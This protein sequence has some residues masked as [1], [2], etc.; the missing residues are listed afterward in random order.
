MAKKFYLAAYRLGRVA[1]RTD[2]WLIAVTAVAALFGGCANSGTGSE[3]ASPEPGRPG[4]IADE[5]TGAIVGVVTDDAFT[6]LEGAAAVLDGQATT[7]TDHGGKFVFGHVA[8]GAHRVAVSLD[9]YQG[10][11]RDVQV[12]A[13]RT[14][15]LSIALLSLAAAQAYHETLIQAGFIACGLSAGAAGQVRQIAVCSVFGS[16]GLGSLDKTFTPWNKYGL[17]MDVTGFWAETTWR[18]TQALSN[19]MAVQW[20][21][22]EKAGDAISGIVT[23]WS[24]GPD[25]IR[26]RVP[27]ELLLNAVV[28]GKKVCADYD[29]PLEA[30]H[31]AWARNNTA[32]DV[33]VVAQQR[34]DDYMTVFH[35][36]ELPV[37]FTALPDK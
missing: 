7:A 35:Y 2:S 29:C 19:R 9:G 16:V 5:D 31:F 8:P 30:W 13:A 37:D 21:A 24:D 12:E 34:Y 23:P 14:A 11:E 32:A 17:G 33:V 26:I 10:Q 27:V 15:E 36:G 20:Y 1:R 3:E 4:E 18:S 22:L 6:P 25:P 28:Q